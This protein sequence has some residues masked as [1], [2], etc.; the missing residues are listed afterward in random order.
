MSAEEK[1]ARG[2]VAIQTL[3]EYQKAKKL[4]ILLIWQKLVRN[5]ILILKKANIS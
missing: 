5:L 4:M 3:Q 2:R 1:M